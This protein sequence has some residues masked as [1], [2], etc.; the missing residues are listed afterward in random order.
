MTNQRILVY[1]LELAPLNTEVWSY[2]PGDS[3]V[4]RV[5]RDQIILS[6]AWQW[7]PDGPIEYKGL[8]DFDTYPGRTRH[9]DLLQA[10]SEIAAHEG[11]GPKKRADRIRDAVA[12]EQA[13]YFDD[14]Q[15]VQ[16][17]WDL[18]N[19]ADVV[20]AH[21]GDRFDNKKARARMFLAGMPPVARPLEYDTL[22]AARRLFSLTSNSLGEI[23]RQLDIAGK[24]SHSG[25]HLWFKCME[26]DPT[27]WAT[28]RDY[29]I[30]DVALLADVYERIRV[31]DKQ[32]PH[33]A[34]ITNRPDGCPQC[35]HTH[36][37]AK[38]WEHTRTGKYRRFL[39]QDCGYRPRSRTVDTDTERPTYV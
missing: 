8:P 37:I 6:A 38:G 34:N 11:W 10:V 4:L 5:N 26:G 21:N 23:A 29:N 7:W 2:Y 17:L 20:V 14:T 15:L 27:A 18:H 32:H 39:C 31:W 12:K 30:Q 24:V 19:Q 33:L 16:L 28:M 3:P 13:A 25:K 35:G 36:V 22:K 9:K 1:D